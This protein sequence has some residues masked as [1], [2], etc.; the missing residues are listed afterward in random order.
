MTHP[1]DVLT[2]LLHV[3][4]A[5]LGTNEKARYV[6]ATLL[7][8]PYMDDNACA[9]RPT[10]PGYYPSDE[11]LVPFL[12][13]C[14]TSGVKIAWFVNGPYAWDGKGDDFRYT[15][16][17]I[18]DYRDVVVFVG[19]HTASHLL[20]GLP[21][22]VD[23][24][25]I[26]YDDHVWRKALG[27]RFRTWVL[28]VP[29]WRYDS[30]L[31]P[32]CR[33]T[34]VRYVLC[35]RLYHRACTDTYGDDVL[36][37]VRCGPVTLVPIIH[38]CDLRTFDEEVKEYTECTWKA[39]GRPSSFTELAFVLCHPNWMAAVQIPEETKILLQA[40]LNETVTA[41][42]GGT[43]I[44]VT[45]KLLDPVTAFDMMNSGRLPVLDVKVPPMDDPWDDFQTMIRRCK[46][47]ERWKE[48]WL[49][50]MKLAWSGDTRVAPYLVRPYCDLPYG[51]VPLLEAFLKREHAG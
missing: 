1:M 2:L 30:A 9:H 40:S 23:V 49:R 43:R 36:E 22:E 11:Y 48:V 13:F 44:D 31:L 38:S 3:L 32:A 4:N 42:Y 28:S 34:G 46:L 47:P 39:L 19:N 12:E 45:L 18:R 20:Y 5:V 14:R 6:H 17:L 37:P 27:D 7:V 15:L 33:E 26:R 25:E 51:D 50:E 21:I 41:W 16:R 8:V 24:A 29:Y 35:G 10:V